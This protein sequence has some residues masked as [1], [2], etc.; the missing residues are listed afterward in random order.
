MDNSPHERND[1]NSGG[2]VTGGG[3]AYGSAHRHGIDEGRDARYAPPSQMRARSKSSGDLRR[4]LTEDGRL[5]LF[6]CK[7]C[8]KCMGD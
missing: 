7:Y 5:I 1:R 2:S 8:F 4:K 3:Y 6:S